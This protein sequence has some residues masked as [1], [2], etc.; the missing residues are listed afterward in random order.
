MGSSLAAQADAAR[1]RPHGVPLSLRF[2]FH[3]PDSPC[4][5]AAMRRI[6]TSLRARPRRVLR[7][8]LSEFEGALESGA[9][10]RYAIH[11]PEFRLVNRRDQLT[12]SAHRVQACGVLRALTAVPLRRSCSTASSE[13]S[14]GDHEA[15]LDSAHGTGLITYISIDKQLS[16]TVALVNALHLYLRRHRLPIGS[17]GRKTLAP[18]SDTYDSMWSNTDLAVS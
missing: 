12:F 18:H 11:P 5:N 16:R 10:R 15:S 6:I 17:G 13:G 2:A 3:T 7:D 14:S 9:R 8:T 1:L 4:G